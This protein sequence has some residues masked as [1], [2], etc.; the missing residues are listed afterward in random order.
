MDR[1]AYIFWANLTPFSL[2]LVCSS[3]GRQRA[4]G[5][6]TPRRPPSPSEVAF[7]HVCVWMGAAARCDCTAAVCVFEMNQIIRCDRIN[8]VLKRLQ[9]QLLPLGSNSTS[10]VSTTPRHPRWA[11][12]QKGPP[13]R[14]RRH[15]ATAWPRLPHARSP[16]HAPWSHSDAAWYISLMICDKKYTKR[17][18]NDSTAHG[19]ARR[20][21]CLVLRR[22]L[23]P[24]GFGRIAA[25]ENRGTEYLIDYGINWMRG[26]WYKA[27]YL[28][29]SSPRT[30]GR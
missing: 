29:W 28:R 25:S 13:P 3:R 5:R 23:A 16:S 4:R 8:L 7:V 6:S 15:P 27:T 2:A 26:P 9:T 20:A 1:P 11:G 18:L 24:I 12:S 19:Y 17:R 30:A 14:T 22:H 10:R 21:P